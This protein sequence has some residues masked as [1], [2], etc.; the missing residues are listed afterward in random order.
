MRNAGGL[1]EIVAEGEI[2]KEPTGERRVERGRRAKY[3]GRI[4]EGTTGGWMEVRERRI[5]GAET[6]FK[7]SLD[8]PGSCIKLKLAN[9]TRYRC[10]L[11]VILIKIATQRRSV[12]AWS[13]GRSSDLR[14]SNRGELW[15]ERITFNIVPFEFLSMFKNRSFKE[16][17]MV[18]NKMTPLR[19]AMQIS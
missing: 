11:I 18:T 1:K 10:N 12:E 3:R 8:T 4:K 6:V 5:E 7:G 14:T 19:K 13:T 2:A 17:S 16:N 9:Q 15:F